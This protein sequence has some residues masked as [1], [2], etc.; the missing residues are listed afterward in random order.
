MKDFFE[1]IF[2]FIIQFLNYINIF[3]LQKLR[4]IFR[5]FW[6]IMRIYPFYLLS[7]YLFMSYTDYAI[8][9][10]YVN[11]DGDVDYYWANSYDKWMW[12]Q[13]TFSFFLGVCLIV[14]L[15]FFLYILFPKQYNHIKKQ[16]FVV[17]SYMVTF[18][19]IENP[20]F[21]DLFAYFCERNVYIMIPFYWVGFWSSLF[22]QWAHDMQE[23]IDIEQEK[24][25]RARIRSGLEPAARVEAKIRMGGL[26]VLIQMTLDGA[27]NDYV[28]TP[29]ETYQRYKEYK[30]RVRELLARDAGMS[31][32]E[33][34][35]DKPT[36]RFREPYEWF[37]HD[38]ITELM[39][40]IQMKKSKSATSFIKII[41]YVIFSIFWPFKCFYDLI[42][43]RIAEYPLYLEYNKNNFIADVQ[44]YMDWRRRQFRRF[45]LRCKVTI[46][47][48]YWA[49]RP[50]PR[51]YPVG[52]YEVQD[53]YYNRQNYKRIITNNRTKRINIKT[54]PKKIGTSKWNL[55]QKRL[56]ISLFENKKNK[57]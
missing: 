28:E 21:P 19:F 2:Y 56:S 12:G 36:L 8:Q 25:D 14:N 37:K 48:I 52:P 6:K 55:A 22:V 27:I 53:P 57:K 31:V 33:F 23:E 35:L 20:I 9:Y 49:M 41:Q 32:E 16:K 13:Q 7:T 26:P 43:L 3:S 24:I 4:T 17:F 18:I 30:I 44:L 47:V 46:Y 54:L 51:I 5:N 40:K 1:W 15:F 45:A 29:A 34:N 38:D 50:I 11:Y 10:E 42:I 39:D